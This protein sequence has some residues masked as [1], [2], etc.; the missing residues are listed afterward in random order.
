MTTEH[1][2]PTNV[3]FQYP[4]QNIGSKICILY[5]TVFYGVRCFLFI[6]ML[7]MEVYK[8]VC[9]RNN[10][11]WGLGGVAPNPLCR[12]ASKASIK[13]YSKFIILAMVHSC[14]TE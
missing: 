14:N 2:K 12:Q 4:T 9:M 8:S 10:D 3:Y 6:I 5:F 1:S 11:N 7:F 13:K